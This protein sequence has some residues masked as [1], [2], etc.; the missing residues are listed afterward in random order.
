MSDELVVRED[1]LEKPLSIAILKNRVQTIQRVMKELMIEGVHFGKI[2]GCG[3][4]P[5]L[6]KA[7]ADLIGTTFS[8]AL[9]PQVIEEDVG[10]NEASYR[11]RV[12]ATNQ[13][14]GRFLGAA[15]GKASTRERKYRWR[16]PVHV[17]EWTA[18][19]PSRRTV[20]FN[21]KGDEE[22]KV[23][24][25][26]GDVANTILQMA[27]KRGSTAVIRTT[28]ACSDIF[29]QDIEDLPEG[30]LQTEPQAPQR[31]SAVA[32]AAAPPTPAP[33]AT[34]GREPGEEEDNG[35]TGLEGPSAYLIEE[36][37][38]AASGKKKDGNPW[39]L[40]AIKTSD[41]KDLV[42]FSSSIYEAAVEAAGSKYPVFLMWTAEEGK[43][44]K[45]RLVLE[46]IKK[47]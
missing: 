33:A 42:T 2:P 28:T 26:P 35:E 1:E 13:S 4:R 18:A 46:E 23:R 3:D 24:Q 12:V 43:D 17:N 27:I 21:R 41:G 36:A 15:E 32:A 44:G 10:E 39:T 25:E 19:D 37:R 20:L 34:P 47:A 9:N 11:V 5:A 7:G 30:Q 29:A 16:W 6:F 38:V 22:K 31:A 8:I 14:N 45:V 40:Y